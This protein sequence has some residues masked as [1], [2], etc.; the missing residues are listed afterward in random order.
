MSESEIDLHVLYL[1]LYDVFIW[2][3]YLI[4]YTL[5]RITFYIWREGEETLVAQNW[6]TVWS[7]KN[8]PKNKSKKMYCMIL[9][10]I[11]FKLRLEPISNILFLIQYGNRSANRVKKHISIWNT[12]K[13]PLSLYTVIRPHSLYASGAFEKFKTIFLAI[14][15]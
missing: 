15:I 13:H 9:H 3:S 14:Q 5:R 10:H 8:V 7:K 6:Y 4:A 1:H 12:I 2:Y 11:M